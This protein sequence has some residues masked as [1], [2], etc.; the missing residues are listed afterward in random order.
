MHNLTVASF[1]GPH[2]HFTLAQL[3][4]FSPVR[5]EEGRRMNFCVGEDSWSS[6]MKE[7]SEAI[8][9]VATLWSLFIT[10]TKR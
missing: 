7:G 8:L 4:T 6:Q 5:D 1:P 3:W 10:Q 9:L 2:M